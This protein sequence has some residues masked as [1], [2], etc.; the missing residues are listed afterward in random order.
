MSKTT[1]K[2]RA[3]TVDEESNH[4]FGYNGTAQVDIEDRQWYTRK[5]NAFLSWYYLDEL[6]WLCIDGMK[7][8]CDYYDGKV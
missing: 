4:L 3:R 7:L 2:K 8:V 5:C 6:E 1:S